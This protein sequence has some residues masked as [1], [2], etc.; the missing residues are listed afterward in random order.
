LERLTPGERDPI[1][2]PPRA[3][4]RWHT[5][6]A[7]DFVQENAHARTL[8]LD[9]PEWPGHVAGQ[10]VDVRLTAEDGYQ[11][12]R[13]YSI[14]SAPEDPHVALT[15]EQIDDGEV[16]PYLVSELRP[17]DTF[18]VRGPIGRP[19]TW[20]EKEGGPLLLLAGGSGLVPLMSMLRHHARRDSQV[21]ARLLVSARREADLLYAD[22][23]A[24]LGMRDPV[25]VFRTFTRAGDPTP[26]AFNRRV[27]ADM[28][29]EVGPPPEERPRIYVCGPTPF[30]ETVADLLVAAGHDP[31]RVSTERFGPTG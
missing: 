29:A 16:S 14:A 27:D 28:L 1:R 20:R 8:L 22:E 4:I 18:E 25:Q 13:S 30:V 26:H 21:D 6:T 12:E 11:A 10:H 24:M 31:A 2:D 7:M 23:L 17:G 9:I 15:I 3:P 5:V 19:F